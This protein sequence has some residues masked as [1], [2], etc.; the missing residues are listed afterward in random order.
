MSGATL[1]HN[2]KRRIADYRDSSPMFC[3]FWSELLSN[4]EF[5]IIGGAIRAIHQNRRPRDIDI[6]VKDGLAEIV[7]ELGR[8]AIVQRNYFGGYKLNLNG[9]LIDIWDFDRHWAFKSGVL[10]AREDNLARS[11]LFDFDAL[12]YSPAT[13]YLDITHYEN[14]LRTKTID[15]VCHDS[16]YIK[17]NPGGLN[18]V[19][20]LLVAA[21]DYNLSFSSRVAAYVISYM[22]K[23]DLSSFSECELRHYNKRMITSEQFN[24]HRRMATACIHRIPCSKTA[25]ADP[26]HDLTHA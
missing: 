6:I 20:R 2:L 5:Y 19:L 4:G 12:I 24:R 15:F 21:E 23:Y 18:N 14:C 16:N 9:L 11:C 13:D 25:V 17:K 1:I 10:D 3:R 26:A 8:D 7:R 22:E